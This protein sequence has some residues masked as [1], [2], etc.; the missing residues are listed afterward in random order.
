MKKPKGKGNHKYT[1]H[2]YDD[3]T[4]YYR[5]GKMHRDEGPAYYDHAIKQKIWYQYGKIHRNDGPAIVYDRDEYY[6]YWHDTEMDFD[7]W[8][9]WTTAPEEKKAELI[10]KYG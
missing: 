3:M 2:N 9:K 7:T 1:I 8:I 10:L 5:F 4:I 6:F